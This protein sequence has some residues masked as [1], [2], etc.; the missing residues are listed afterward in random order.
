MKFV[1]KLGKKVFLRISTEIKKQAKKPKRGAKDSI[2]PI[3]SVFK[4]NENFQEMRKSNEIV[5][6][7]SKHDF[8]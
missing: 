1:I 8:C 4:K 7:I 2:F 5:K 6:R 3:G